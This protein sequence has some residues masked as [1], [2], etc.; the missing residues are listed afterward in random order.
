MNNN[1]NLI[2]FGTFG[3]PNGY[4]QTF[5]KGNTEY[6]SLL[7]F[8]LNTSAIK[9][10]ANT[11]MYAIRRERING[12]NGL[13][14]SI[15]TFA[16]EQNSE[17]GGTFI[18]SSLL[19]IDEHPQLNLIISILNNFH[20][21]LVKYNVIN[22]TIQVNHSDNLNVS[23][24]IPNDFEKLAL[25]NI[26][27]EDYYTNLNNNQLL[28][29]DY[30]DS[31]NL[32]LILNDA[33]EL[34]NN[35]NTIFVSADREIVKFVHQ[36]GLMPFVS[37]ENNSF[38]T[39]LKKVKEL[40][41]NLITNSI[42]KYE[43]EKRLLQIEK[44]NE[45]NELK[46][47]LQNDKLLQAENDKIINQNSQYILELETFYN[48]QIEKVDKHILEL[49]NSSNI[50]KTDQSYK[51]SKAEFQNNK[52]SKKQQKNQNKLNKVKQQQQKSTNS[53]YNTTTE[54]I[55]FSRPPQEVSL[56][57]DRKKESKN[58]YKILTYSF[59]LLWITT[60][61][62]LFLNNTKEISSNQQQINSHKT[63]NNSKSSI[64]NSSSNLTP[65][66]TTNLNSNDLHF[67]NK[68]KLK[69]KNIKEIVEIIFNKNP[70]GI[71]KYYANQIELYCKLLIEQNT[72]CFR[73]KILVADSLIII[74]SN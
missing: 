70:N 35:Y 21:N 7:K 23:F 72:N 73:D 3:N 69:G 16:K 74:P 55:H 17:R 13:S 49:K 39:E 38:E 50:S 48:S 18:G 56:E 42:S 27:I 29:Y 9:L 68:V 10:V 63:E 26:R 4:R 41:Q 45:I 19:F 25:N 8:D 31:E 52:I 5:I 60:T 22:E 6:S 14:F 1:I 43:Q 44:E 47:H 37:K 2:A 62:F 65:K 57:E 66:P 15:Y 53:N 11:K 30:V 24:G 54:N 64:S 20:Y 40:K 59:G 51:K 32:P 46:N 71:K 58:L 61:I 67:V 36:R 28:I 34:L 12:R 33:K